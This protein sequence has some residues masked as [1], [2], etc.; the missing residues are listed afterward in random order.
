MDPFAYLPAHL[1][2]AP[3]PLV[4]ELLSSWLGR[5]AAA[6]ALGFGEL[7]ELVHQRL[8]L[9]RAGPFDAGRLDY[10]CS[11]PLLKTLSTLSRLPATSI[12]ALSLKRRFGALGLFWFNHDTYLFYNAQHRLIPRPQILPS[13]CAECLREQAQQG[14]AAHLRVEWAL[15]FLTH[16][17][18][19]R[20]G[21]WSCCPDCRDM[22]SMG[23][24][25]GRGQP[26]TRGC[27]RCA[28]RPW[29][30]FLEPPQP[31]SRRQERV[32]AL[33]AA[34]LG[35][36]G[37]EGSAPRAPDP[38]WVG[39]VRPADFVRLVSELLEML[40][41]P[42]A[43]GGF[44]LLEHLQRG[45]CRAPEEVW[46]PLP[47]GSEPFG[48]LGRQGRFEL[49][50]GVVEL[51]GI[52]LGEDKPSG[53]PAPFG[54]LYGPMSASRRGAFLERLKSWPERVRVKA[55]AAARSF[56]TPEPR[57]SE[58]KKEDR[59]RGRPTK[60]QRIARKASTG[61]ENLDTLASQIG[62]KRGGVLRELTPKWAFKCA[63][64]RMNCK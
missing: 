28:L 14:Q 24:G 25:L 57:C 56:K 9:L 62:C 6:N 64:S 46:R 3:R 43:R 45:S 17:P 4:G 31:L 23:W 33:E 51:L 52:G 16:C 26:P 27:R 42:D 36:V 19:H 50:A 38:G 55:L 47:V 15:A 60:W 12:A 39:A 13:Y 2:V 32:L 40:G 44:S 34:L 58:K 11:G 8:A 30:A 20:L 1:P 5:L 54:C 18:R 35:A 37:G 59:G 48:A 53:N 22:A 21:L 10:A 29:I 61:E 63:A 41:W 49:L 7:L